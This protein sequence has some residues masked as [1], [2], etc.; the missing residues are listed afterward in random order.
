[1]KDADKKTVI[2]S[3]SVML[4]ILGLILGFLFRRLLFDTFSIGSWLSIIAF[5]MSL[6]A[7]EDHGNNVLARAAFWMGTISI[8]A[9]IFWGAM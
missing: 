9:T 6:G 7:V 3:A 2:G 4:S 5:L 1:M 8:F